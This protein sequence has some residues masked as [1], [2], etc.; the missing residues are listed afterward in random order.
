MFHQLPGESALKLIIFSQLNLKNV[1]ARF[2]TLLHN[3]SGK[4][5]ISFAD[6]K[7]L[8]AV[9]NSYRVNSRV[10]ASPGS[11]DTATGK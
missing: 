2:Q 9:Y 5:S 7:M 8:C 4:D 6:A 11:P 3:Q 10:A 1:F